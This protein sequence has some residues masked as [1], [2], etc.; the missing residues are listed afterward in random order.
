MKKIEADNYKKIQI[1]RLLRD[2]KD[3]GRSKTLSWGENGSSGT[4]IAS[5]SLMGPEKYAR[6]TY[7]QTD[8]EGKTTD[9]DYKVPITETP[10]KFGGSRYWFTCPL[11]KNGQHCGRRIGVLYKVGNYFGCRHCFDLTYKS[12]NTNRR[13]K[14]FPLFKAFEISRKLENLGDAKRY[15]YKGK[16][17]KRFKKVQE[18]EEQSLA[19]IKNFAAIERQS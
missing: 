18:L 2:V 16:L 12:K 6:L 10:C 11:T 19:N 8:S 4:I 15:T 5:V 3:D 13:D 1:W 17:T 14:Y 9:F 7:S